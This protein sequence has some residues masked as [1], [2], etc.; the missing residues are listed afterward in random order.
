MK[1][2]YADRDNTTVEALVESSAEEKKAE[3]VAAA[4][5]TATLPKERFHRIK[6]FKKKIFGN[7]QHKEARDEETKEEKKE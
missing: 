2:K 3:S 7:E 5:E 6:N 1:G 4:S